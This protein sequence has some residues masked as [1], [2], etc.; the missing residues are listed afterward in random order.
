MIIELAIR[1]LT[2]MRAN[3]YVPIY[4]TGGGV[5]LL[6]GGKDYISKRLGE[7]IEIIASKVPGLSK[8]NYSSILGLLELALNS[9]QNEKKSFWQRLFKK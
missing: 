8:P 4:L 2:Q 7:N 5:C 3:S 1:S 6:K 9:K